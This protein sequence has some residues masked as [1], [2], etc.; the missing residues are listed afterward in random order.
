MC[1]GHTVTGYFYNPN[2]H[3]ADEY[4]KRLDAAKKV[5]KEIGFEFI[6]GKYDRENW[7]EL[8]KGTEYEP[9]GGK[10]CELCFRMRLKDTYEYSKKH[11]FDKFTTTLSVSPHKDVVLVNQIGREIGGEDFICADFKKKNGFQ[12]AMEMAKEMG[13][14]RQGYCGCIYSKEEMLKKEKSGNEETV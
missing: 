14:Y 12:R 2:I 7:F 3:P 10:R 13:L 8:I 11:M 5:A 9:E 4:M 6:E 1:E